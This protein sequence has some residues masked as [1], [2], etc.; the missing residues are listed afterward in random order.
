VKPDGCYVKSSGCYVKLDV[1]TEC[2]YRER[3]LCEAGWMLCETGH[4][5]CCCAV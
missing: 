3:M 2:L 1:L 5:Y 4:V